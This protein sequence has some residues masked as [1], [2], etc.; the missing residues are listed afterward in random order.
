MRFT[1]TD[2]TLW[3]FTI[4]LFNETDISSNT[5][6]QVTPSSA[7]PWCSVTD[8]D[9][10]G[11]RSREKIQKAPI[12]EKCIFALFFLSAQL[13]LFFS[14]LFHTLG[15]HSSRIL[16]IF[17][18]LDY[19]GIALLTMGSFVPWV[20]YTFYCETQSKIVY[21]VTISVLGLTAILLSQWERFAQPQYRCVT[22][23]MLHIVCI[24][25]AQ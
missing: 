2:F 20:Y 12:E 21:M 7:T 8:I 9:L 14:T 5:A 22:Y 4:T 11:Q 13:C 3:S 23:D 17:G 1:G 16:H 6:P 18:K 15:C 19:S 10:R 25:T 24:R